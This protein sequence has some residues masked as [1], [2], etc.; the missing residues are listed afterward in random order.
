VMS[1]RLVTVWLPVVVWAGVIF[2]FSSIPG[3]GTD[4]GVWDTI[5][6]KLAHV[7]EYAILGALLLRALGRELAAFALGLGY[8]ITD[9]IH[10]HFVQGRHGAPLDVAIDAG[11]L[12]LGILILRSATARASS[13]RRLGW[14]ER[15]R[16]I[17]RDG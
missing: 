4:L 14:V 1:S 8:A 6:R 15:P 5:L 11:G 3:L 13:E 9:E 17:E 12:L 16:R 7:T 10:Q 2:T